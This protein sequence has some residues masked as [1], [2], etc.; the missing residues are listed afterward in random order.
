MNIKKVIE[1][2]TIP[3]ESQLSKFKLNFLDELAKDYAK[4]TNQNHPKFSFDE[5]KYVQK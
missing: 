4:K 3:H 5:Q 2:L 1:F